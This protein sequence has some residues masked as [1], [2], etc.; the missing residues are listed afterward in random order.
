MIITISGDP[1]SGKSTLAKM[2]AQK[3]DMK[4][5]SMGNIFREQAR[6]K[7]MSLEEY[8]ELGAKDETIDKEADAYQTN[9]GKTEDNFIIEGRTSFYFIPNS[10]KLYLTV[11]ELEGANRIWRDLQ[12]SDDRN[13]AKNINS[14]NDLVASIKR[15]RKSEYERYM[16]YYNFDAFDM[17][18]FDFILDATG[19]SPDETFQ[20]VLT[21]IE[22]KR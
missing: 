8:Y 3:L 11:N 6:Q 16:K 14:L 12:K 17:K 15:R 1:G 10:L 13:E 21:F 18:N 7:N 4:C 9:L 22:T 19:L 2:L 5:Y 20:K